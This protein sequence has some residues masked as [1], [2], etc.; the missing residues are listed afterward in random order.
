MALPVPQHN[1]AI[2][3]QNPHQAE[4]IH[5]AKL[6]GDRI[7]SKQLVWTQ[8]NSFGVK[9]HRVLPLL[10]AQFILPPNKYY[11]TADLSVVSTLFMELFSMHSTQKRKVVGNN[12]G[13]RQ[14]REAEAAG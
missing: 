10:L 12:R 13:R 6:T 14:S 2:C 4:Q 9:T 8:V 3:R 5:W 7:K 11:P 1:W